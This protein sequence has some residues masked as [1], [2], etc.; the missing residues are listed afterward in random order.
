M[1]D[2]ECSLRFR[3]AATTALGMMESAGASALPSLIQAMEEADTLV[4]SELAAALGVEAAEL[5]REPDPN[6]A[7]Q[8]MKA[9]R[10]R[11][12]EPAE[13]SAGQPEPVA[14]AAPKKGR[15]GKGRNEG[16]SRASQDPH[17][18]DGCPGRSRFGRLALGSETPS[19]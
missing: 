11:K 4:R 18:R 5:L 3:V 12:V 8:P 9:G 15:K 17:V 19:G 13:P 1:E 16:T 14:E 10:P 7:T 6:L 2:K